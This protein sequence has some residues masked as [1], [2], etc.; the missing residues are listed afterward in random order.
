MS[1]SLAGTCIRTYKSRTPRHHD[2]AILVPFALLDK[3][4]FLKYPCHDL[5]SKMR[6][7]DGSAMHGGLELADVYY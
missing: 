1:T 6:Q 7:T 4:Q 2:F 3:A 5:R